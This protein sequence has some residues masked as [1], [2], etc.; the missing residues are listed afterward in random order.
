MI[1]IQDAFRSAQEKW[2]MPPEPPVDYTESSLNFYLQST[3]NRFFNNCDQFTNGEYSLF[4]TFT[5]L[6]KTVV[7][8]GV[9]NDIY[10]VEVSDPLTH[11]YLFEPHPV[12]FKT[13]QDT[14]QE[15]G[16]LQKYPFLSLLNLGVSDSS[17]TLAYYEKAESFVNRWN[18]QPSQHLPVVR[19]DSLENL[20]AESEI[21]FLKV[22]T[23]GYELDVLRSAEGLLHKTKLI[24]FEYG[25]TYPHRGIQLQ[26]V[27]RYLQGHQ[28]SYFYYLNS[29]GIFMMDSQNIV[30]H[31]QYS[32][33]LASKISL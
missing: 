15:K 11:L 2:N 22:D 6:F 8:V 9:R 4:K 29:D 5:P 3:S 25:G 1:S 18:E 14:L 10:Y 20:Q 17:G 13:L 30:E 27:I 19:L 12:F 26:D 21:S 32:N 33:I 24:Q 31:Q 7:D 28:F 23:E 16:L